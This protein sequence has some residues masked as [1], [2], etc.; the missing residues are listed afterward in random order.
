[1]A[2][3][4]RISLCTLCLNE[5]E[6]LEKSYAQHKDWPGLV[7]WHFVEGAD[8]KYGEAAPDMVTEDGLS[9]DRT[10][11][12][13]DDLCAADIRVTYNPYGWMFDANEAQAKTKGRDRYLDRLEKVRPDVFLVLDADEFYTHEDQRKI[14]NLIERTYDNYLCWRLTQRHVWHPPY[15]NKGEMSFQREVIGGYW[16][17]RHVRIFKWRAGL[18]YRTDHNWPIVRGYYPTHHLYDGELADPVCIHLGFA[19]NARE[20]VAT[21]N[22][23]KQRGEG[24]GDGR[25]RYVSCRA[26]WETWRP[27][28]KLPN[29]ARVV[30]YTGPI[31]ECYL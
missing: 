2:K 7:S 18:R 3:S 6:F 5:G 11:E 4:L 19:R 15:F 23:Y 27:G 10:G 1:M 14:N 29:A 26:A 20:R 9:V 16:D 24:R 21:N 8:K 30:A 25:Q 22:Y 28:R 31:P 13:L 17:V 12:I